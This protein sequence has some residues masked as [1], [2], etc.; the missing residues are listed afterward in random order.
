M[1]ISETMQPQTVGQLL[2]NELVKMWKEWSWPNLKYYPSS[3]PEGM[4][5]I[6]RNLMTK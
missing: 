5:E 4:K 3:F 1:S 6:I 2:N